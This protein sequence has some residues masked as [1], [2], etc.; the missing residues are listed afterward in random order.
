[1]APWS[2]HRGGGPRR[3][4]VVARRGRPGPPP[5]LPPPRTAGRPPPAPSPAPASRGRAR[6]SARAVP[7]SRTAP[8][9]MD[10]EGKVIDVGD[11]PDQGRA[12]GH[13]ALPLAGMAVHQLE[14]QLLDEES[15][16]L[17]DHLVCACGGGHA[18]IIQA[19]T[20]KRLRAKGIPDETHHQVRRARSVPP[21]G[22]RI[23][24]A[25]L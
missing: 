21:G 14:V 10:P 15:E 7:S 11:H 3:D 6:P 24:G 4:A 12:E 2:A 19:E 16:R 9:H 18:G 17:L 25:L 5:A 13:R 20:S 22:P 1:M 23:G 8:P